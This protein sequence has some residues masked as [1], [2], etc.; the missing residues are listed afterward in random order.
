MIELVIAKSDGIER[1]YRSRSFTWG[2]LHYAQVFHRQEMPAECSVPDGHWM[3]LAR[4]TEL[5]NE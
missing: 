1:L 4:A 3:T 2:P 5:E